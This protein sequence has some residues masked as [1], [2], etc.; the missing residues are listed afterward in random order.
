MRPGRSILT[1]MVIYIRSEMTAAII[2]VV[3]DHALSVC[4]D[5]SGGGGGGGWV[6]RTLMYLTWVSKAQC[7]HKVCPFLLQTAGGNL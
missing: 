2:V 3:D 4:S 6:C 7:L 5:V 1:V